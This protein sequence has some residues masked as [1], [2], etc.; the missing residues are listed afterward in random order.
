MFIIEGGYN[1]E[2]KHFQFVFKGYTF[3]FMYFLW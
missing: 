2:F 1:I 3:M